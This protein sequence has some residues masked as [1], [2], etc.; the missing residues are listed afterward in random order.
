MYQFVVFFNKKI[1]HM[2]SQRHVTWQWQCNVALG[3]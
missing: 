1:I 3:L 2:S